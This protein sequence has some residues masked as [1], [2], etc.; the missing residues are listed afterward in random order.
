MDKIVVTYMLEDKYW[1]MK[2]LQSTQ[3]MKERNKGSLRVIFLQV[4][5]HQ[6]RRRIPRVI[7]A[8]KRKI[9]LG[10][11]DIISRWKFGSKEDWKTRE[12]PKSIF[13]FC[14]SSRGCPYVILK[15]ILQGNYINFVVAKKVDVHGD[16]L[17]DFFFEFCKFVKVDNWKVYKR[18]FLVGFVEV[19][20]VCYHLDW[21][22]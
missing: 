11:G 17:G 9:K 13:D 10:K 16:L 3:V 19:M 22:K 18:Y 15:I 14:R 4:G 6:A 7:G 5:C 8:Q 21:K 12:E 1:T 2:S 20:Y